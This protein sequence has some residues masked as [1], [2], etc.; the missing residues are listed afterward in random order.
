MLHLL[1]QV[2]V[3]VTVLFPNKKKLKFTAFVLKWFSRTKVMNTSIKY[4]QFF[5]ALLLICTVIIQKLFTVF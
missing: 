3:R 2:R 4:F 1:Q 5:K